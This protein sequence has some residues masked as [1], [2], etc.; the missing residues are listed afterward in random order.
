[1]PSLCAEG[2]LE[3][4]AREAREALGADTIRKCLIFAPDALGAH[5]WPVRRNQYQSISQH[6]PV[7]VDLCSVIPP[8]TP[9]CFASMFTGAQP[10][11]HGIR[12]YTRPVLECDT[13]F[14]VLL[15][16][17]HRVAIV[18]VRDSSIDLIFRNREMDYYC[19]ENDAA[20]WQRA[21]E[22]FPAD[23]HDVIV[24]YQQEYDDTLHVTEPYS[25]AC[26]EA[27]ANHVDSFNTLAAA[28]AR[29][30]QDHHHAVIFAPDHGAHTDPETGRGD[31]G[32]NIPDDMLLY[33]WY[34][35]WAGKT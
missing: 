1:M 3:A 33:H 5:V 18:A 8:K 28:T 15:H 17:G 16:A 31:H 12:E 30:W 35:V 23:R 26:L 13:L 21:L 19:E 25:A 32:L 20:V 22:L 11:D 7:R 27:V 34:G 24:A 29:H 6:A 4:V 14:D 10:A 2:P 9:A